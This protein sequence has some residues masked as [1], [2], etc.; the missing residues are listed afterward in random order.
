MR[1]RAQTDGNQAAIVAALRKVG[2]SVA[3]TAEVGG[4]YP[5]LTV[6]YRLRTYLL[7]VKDPRQQPNKQRLTEAQEEF[8]RNW[9]GAPI[10]IVRTVEQA[11]FACEVTRTHRRDAGFQVTPPEAPPFDSADCRGLP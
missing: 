6:G 3:I 8:H 1:R 9:H 4:G 11:F 7:E 5:D 2:A 10:H